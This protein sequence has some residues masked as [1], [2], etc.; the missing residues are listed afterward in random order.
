VDLRLNGASVGHLEGE[1]HMRLV[2]SIAV[3]IAGVVL[4]GCGTDPV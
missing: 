2:T 4:A 1:M 3:V